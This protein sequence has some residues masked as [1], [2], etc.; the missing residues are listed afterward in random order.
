MK[1]KRILSLLATL[2][3]V[4]ITLIAIDHA[5]ANATPSYG[6][7]SA[8][9]TSGLGSTTAA[10]V[11]MGLDDQGIRD[12][13]GGFT[14]NSYSSGLDIKGTCIAGSCTQAPEIEIFWTINH[15]FCAAPAAYCFEALSSINGLPFST[16]GY[17]EANVGSGGYA[18]DGSQYIAF[19]EGS[20]SHPVYL[21]YCLSSGRINIV[22]ANNN[23]CSS[24]EIVGY[25]PTTTWG[26]GQ[27]SFGTITNETVLDQVYN[28]DGGWTGSKVPSIDNTLEYFTDNGGNS[29]G[30]VSNNESGIY[31]VS[32]ASGTGFK[33]DGGQDE[34]DSVGWPLEGSTNG[35]VCAKVY[36]GVY[37]ANQPVVTNTCGTADAD[38]SWQYDSLTGHIYITHS[39][40]NWCITDPNDSITNGTATVI[41]TCG[42]GHGQDWTASASD[43]IVVWIDYS[44]TVAL[45]DT[46][47]GGNGTKVQVWVINNGAS[48]NWSPFFTYA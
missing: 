31:T 38:M 10:Y 7:V 5:P 6:T 30:S 28:Y 26:T 3:I 14:A 33:V 45:D 2:A 43:G 24:T 32:N 39:G 47:G 1:K 9:V 44:N 41:Q 20:A 27:T 16:T 22:A 42:T 40:T 36:G 18:D 17:V 25:F 15:G 11:G 4:P 13:T 21:G 19:G 34:D 46:A 12:S 35:G 23:T 29:L 37:Q 8:S 48:Q